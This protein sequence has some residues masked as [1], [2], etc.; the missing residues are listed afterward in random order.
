MGR[1][2]RGYRLRLLYAPSGLRGRGRPGSVRMYAGNEDRR[3]HR[4]ELRSGFRRV[5]RHLQLRHVLP[6]RELRG[7]DPRHRRRLR[8][9]PEAPGRRLRLEGVRDGPRRV[10]RDCQLR[11]LRRERD[12]QRLVPR[13]LRPV[14]E[15]RW[16][17]DRRTGLPRRTS[18]A[19]PVPEHG[20]RPS[21]LRRD[22]LH[23]GNHPG[24]PVLLH[25]LM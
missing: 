20:L 21:G 12:L 5:R 14:P 16:A 11:D 13:P 19:A 25:S 3:L 22:V 18:R 23:P 24:R 9:H 10:R 6:A 1:L 8:V 17:P 15:R 7:A 4:K 2:Y